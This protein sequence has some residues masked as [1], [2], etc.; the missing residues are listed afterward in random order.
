M[1]IYIYIYTDICIYIYIYTGGLR[2]RGGG[3]DD[4]A[5]AVREEGRQGHSG[6]L[7]LQATII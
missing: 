7:R 1:H 4:L 6:S 2:R 5:R 3:C